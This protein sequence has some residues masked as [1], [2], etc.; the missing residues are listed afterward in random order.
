VGPKASIGLLGGSFNPAHEGHRYVSEVAKKALGLDAVWWLVSP[1]NPLKSANGMAPLS[2][3]MASAAAVARHPRIH[4]TDIERNLG[5]R[6]TAD[7]IILEIKAVSGL[8]LLIL[9]NLN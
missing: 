5:T 2:A 8:L 6:F 7:K 1:Q 3:R 4:A 9:M